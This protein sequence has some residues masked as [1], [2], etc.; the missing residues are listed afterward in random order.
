MRI[1]AG[2]SLRAFLP[3]DKWQVEQVQSYSRQYRYDQ[4]VQIPLP[5][6]SYTYAQRILVRKEKVRPKINAD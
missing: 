3:S 4:Q 6:L 2:L 1:P 5:Q